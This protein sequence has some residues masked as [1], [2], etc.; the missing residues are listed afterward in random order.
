VSGKVVICLHGLCLFVCTIVCRC[1]VIIFIVE[2][3][4][5]RHNDTVGGRGVKLRNEEFVIYKI[6]GAYVG[7][8]CSIH[9][10]I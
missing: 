6:Q 8:E 10:G 5:I 9:E 4:V 2:S 1:F 7:G 3:L